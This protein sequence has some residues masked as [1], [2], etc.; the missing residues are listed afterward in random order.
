MLLTAHTSTTDAGRI[1]TTLDRIECELAHKRKLFQDNRITARGGV[2]S[3]WKGYAEPPPSPPPE[4]GTWGDH[5]PLPDPVAQAA[6][7]LRHGERCTAL[8]LLEPERG[9]GPRSA[10]MRL[11][12][13][14]S[15]P[16][17][18]CYRRV[19]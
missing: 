6:D 5:P 16:G 15:Y 9:F 12:P 11:P 7:A 2:P 14:R 3:N 18:D 19:R 8:G 10:L 13:D 4:P 1:L 17:G